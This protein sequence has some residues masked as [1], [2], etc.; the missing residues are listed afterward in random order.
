MKKI[1][2]LILAVAL[3]IAPAAVRSS[4]PPADPTPTAAPA[5]VTGISFET[6]DRDGHTVTQEVLGENVLTMLNFWEPWC[7]PCVREM[8][9][10]QK[11]SQDYAD[12]GFAILGIY[13]TPGMESDVDEVLSH[14]GVTYPILHYV[15]SFDSFQTG[16]VPTTVF[17]DSH[18]N[19]VGEIQI[20]GRSY[21]DWAALVE[22]LL[23]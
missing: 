8:P 5:E 22:E 20:G 18:G 7:G 23:G 3:G 4:A 21:S 14:A 11:L 1:L 9:D 16:Y 6:T 17:L 2:L 19:R 15:D 10:L 12:R 13:S